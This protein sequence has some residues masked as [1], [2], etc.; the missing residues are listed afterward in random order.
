MN[1]QSG[2]HDRFSAWRFY[3]IDGPIVK[4]LWTAICGCGESFGTFATVID[5]MDAARPHYEDQP[6]EEPA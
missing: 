1:V 3:D 4:H 5:A 6:I 2:P